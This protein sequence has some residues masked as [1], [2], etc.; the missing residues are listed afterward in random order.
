MPNPAVFPATEEEEAGGGLELWSI[1]SPGAGGQGV[2]LQGLS[3]GWGLQMWLAGPVGVPALRAAEA[4]LPPTGVVQRE[5]ELPPGTTHLAAAAQVTER[6]VGQDNPPQLHGEA[7]HL[8]GSSSSSSRHTGGEH[9]ETAGL[10]HTRR[11][12]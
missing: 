10:T 8:H 5:D 9:L 7:A 12:S 6:K 3:P 2:L 11:R 4:E 1:L